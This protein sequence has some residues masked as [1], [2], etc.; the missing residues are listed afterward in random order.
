GS[1]SAAI[2]ATVAIRLCFMNILLDGRLLNGSLWAGSCASNA[3]SS[4]RQ[5]RTPLAET[6]VPSAILQRGAVSIDKGARRNNE[7]TGR[8]TFMNIKVGKQAIAEATQKLKNWGR[9]GKDDQVGTLNHVTPEDIVKAASLIR[10]GKV[11]ALGIPLDRT[12]PQ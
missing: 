5:R 1:V 12:G 8:N 7:K 4:K 10:S 9:W 11:F 2:I 6:P 3:C